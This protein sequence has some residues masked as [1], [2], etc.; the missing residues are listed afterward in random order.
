M[1]YGSWAMGFVHKSDNCEREGTEGVGAVA[2]CAANDG[3][4]VNV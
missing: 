4:V 1:S 2:V 3:G